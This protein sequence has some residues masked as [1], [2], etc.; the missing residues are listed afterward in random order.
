MP[1]RPANC[2]GW[3]SRPPKSSS[4]SPGQ[5]VQLRVLAHWND[6][7]VE[8][9]TEITR[10][11]TNDETVANVTEAG[12]VSCTGKGD[13]HIVASYDNGVVP[14]PVM[15]PVSEFAGQQVPGV[16]TPHARSTNWC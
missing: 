13:S 10:F 1:T 15:L 9:V 2:N 14:I 3:K 6:G 7:T 11:K 5:S 16:T 4:P 12:L 8:D